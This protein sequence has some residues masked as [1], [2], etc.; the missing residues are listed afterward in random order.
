MSHDKSKKANLESTKL[1][2]SKETIRTLQVQ[3]GVQTG[4]KVLTAVSCK[5][6]PTEVTCGTTCGW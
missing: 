4:M 6:G 2:L 3:S 5:C 1:T